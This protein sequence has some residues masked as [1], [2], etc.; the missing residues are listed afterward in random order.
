MSS[1]QNYRFIIM[2]RFSERLTGAITR[3]LADNEILV[4]VPGGSIHTFFMS[5]PIDV[6]F[7]SSDGCVLKIINA[8]KPWRLALAPPKTCYTL[9]SEANMAGRAFN[10]G[11]VIN[12]G[13][14]LG[15]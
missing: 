6:L 4:F 2:H 13:V 15:D 3:H 14:M 10:I 11:D 7:I 8:I 9:E 5:R 1:S 12:T